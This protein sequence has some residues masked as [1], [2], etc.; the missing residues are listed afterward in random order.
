[1][2]GQGPPVSVV[3][4][5]EVKVM[6]VPPLIA[7][8]FPP[9]LPKSML[10]AEAARGRPATRIASAN[11]FRYCMFFYPL[12]AVFFFLASITFRKGRSCGRKD[13]DVKPVLANLAGS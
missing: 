13:K 9:V 5:E 12:S 6:A 7:V 2:V 8:T 11:I 4:R 10:L 3:R 1:V